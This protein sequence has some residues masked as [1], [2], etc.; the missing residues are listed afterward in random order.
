MDARRCASTAP[1]PSMDTSASFFDTY[2]GTVA[3]SR[4]AR[5]DARPRKQ[6]DDLRPRRWHD[7]IHVLAGGDITRSSGAGTATITVP[8]DNDSTSSVSVQAGTLALT[9]VSGARPRPASSTPPPARRSTSPAAPTP[10]AAPSFTGDGTV[11]VS[12]GQLEHRRRVLGRRADDARLTNCDARQRRRHDYDRKRHPGLGT[13]RPSPAS[14]DDDH[15]AGTLTRERRGHLSGPST[16]RRCTST[17]PRPSRA[18]RRQLL[19][20]LHAERRRARDRLERH[21]QPRR[22]PDDLRPRRH[23]PIHVLAGG[24]LTEQR[25]R[26]RVHHGPARQ[27]QHQQRQRPGGH[28]RAQRRQRRATSTGQFNAATGATIDFA[29]DTHPPAAPLHRRR[30]RARSPRATLSTAGATSVAA[31]RRSSSPTGRSP[32]PGAT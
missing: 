8:L 21:A 29:G 22:Q 14:D 9:A 7:P 19:R 28:A 11:R 3:S 27:R 18:H 30:H 16:T 25:R 6:P 13:T 4:W 20:H 31:R 2:I 1:R 26:H 17:A 32:T 15:P 24:D 23:D 5:A 12:S 10:P